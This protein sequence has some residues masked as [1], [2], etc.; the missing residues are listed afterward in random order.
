MSVLHIGIMPTGES[1]TSFYF[2]IFLS[3][4]LSEFLVLSSFRVPLL[5]L[6]NTYFIVNNVRLTMES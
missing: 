5:L 2:Y 3:S 6:S 4:F 1:D